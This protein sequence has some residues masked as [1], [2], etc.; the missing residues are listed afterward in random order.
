MYK[1]TCLA[2]AAATLMVAPAFAPA[3]AQESIGTLQ[4]EGRVMSSS[5]G[6]FALA[7]TGDAVVSGQR[8]LVGEGGQAS[9]RFADG[10]VV[11]YTEPGVYTVEMPASAANATAGEV[12]SPPPGLAPATLIAGAAVAGAVILS[13]GG[14]DDDP[15]ISR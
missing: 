9:V 4:V 11:R 1:P 6:T 14:D 7:S 3:M 15:P 5:G 12:G 2:L 10:S 13:S 8:I